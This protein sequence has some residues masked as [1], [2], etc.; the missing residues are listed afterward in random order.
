MDLNRQ[1]LEQGAANIRS[2]RQASGE[3]PTVTTAP[4]GDR[5]I[6]GKYGSGSATSVPSGAKRPEGLVNGRPFSEVMQGLANK[7]G[8]LGTSRPTDKFQPQT[9][10]SA[11]YD[12]SP[13]TPTKD[14]IN[15]QRMSLASTKR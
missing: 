2:Q 1:A 15:K 9:G 4:S 3:L 14:D 11:L 8:N 13:P 10:G 6:Q 12:K 7:Q 5:T